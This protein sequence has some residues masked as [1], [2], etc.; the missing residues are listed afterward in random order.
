LERHCKVSDRRP[1]R[2]RGDPPAFERADY[3]WNP[4]VG[5]G[6]YFWTWTWKKCSWTKRNERGQTCHLKEQGR[7]FFPILGLPF[8]R[9]ENAPGYP[10]EGAFFGSSPLVRKE[11]S[12]TT[13]NFQVAAVRPASRVHLRDRETMRRG[14]SGA[15]G[16]GCGS[17]HV[18][19]LSTR[20]V[21]LRRPELYYECAATPCC[22]PIGCITPS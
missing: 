21:W 2:S 20:D 19:R 7:L 13:S 5:A 11:N 10:R 14:S 6:S 1:L 17:R 9:S 16:A 22:R 15:V 12:K 4:G 3:Y 18:S 8:R